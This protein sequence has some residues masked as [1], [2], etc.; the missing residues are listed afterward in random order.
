M[1]KLKEGDIF[2]MQISEASSAIG[3]I[4]STAQ[5]G[6][7]TIIVFEGLYE[8]NVMPSPAEVTKDDILFFANTFDAKFYHKH[9]I[10][11]GN[12][13]ANLG[14]IKLPIYKLG[15]ED[16]LRYEDFFM[17]PIANES[18][19]SISERNKVDYR[20]YIAPV[21]VENAVKGFYKLLDWS[22][23][24]DKLLYKNLVKHP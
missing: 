12:Y 7:L 15:T 18:L 17:K 23:D 10:V 4:V 22:E 20:N 11:M 24:Y 2:R 1:T 13:T 16:A 14:S 19:P 21:R 6:S 8:A 5:K 9:W 3:Q